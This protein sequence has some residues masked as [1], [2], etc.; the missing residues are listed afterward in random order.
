MSK[1]IKRNLF[2]LILLL[3]LMDLS[4]CAQK[5]DFEEYEPKSTLV[6]PAHTITHSKY[7]FID[8]HNHQWDMPSQDLSELIREMDKL[9]MAI[10][11]NLSGRGYREA[12]GIFDV[13]DSTYFKKAQ[14]NIRAHYPT[15]FTEFSNLSFAQFGQT[16]WTQRALAN[17]EADVRNGA[18]GLKIYKDLGME[19]RD[20]QGKRI[21]VDD[22]RLDPIWDKCGALHIPVLIHSAD[23]SSFW[24]PMDKYN[25]RWLELKTHPDR[26]RGNTNPA[27]W[28][29][30]IEEQHHLFRAHPNTQF[31]AA[32]F[33]WLANDLSSLGKL[34]DECPNVSVEIAAI[35]AELGRQPRQAREFFIKYQDRIL[36]GKDSWVPSEYLTYFRVLETADEYFPYHKKYHAFWRMYGLALP[37]EVLKKVYYKN[38]L[39]LLPGLDKSRFPQ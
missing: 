13:Q 14:A 33:G 17:L 5:M 10:M 35:I 19:F 31:I 3:C 30:I 22:P 16:D 26:R 37:D 20:Q 29:T 2:L 28:K 11:N 34:L 8:I 23:P 24:D 18:K 1:L 36:F 21:P 27:P 7:P 15:R 32:H 25:E 4:A 12:N 39:R 6:V 38:A 9:N